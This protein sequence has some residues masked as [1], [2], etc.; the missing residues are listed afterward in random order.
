MTLSKFVKKQEKPLNLQIIRRIVLQLMMQFES[1]HEN[2][3]VH[4]ELNPQSILVTDAAL[5]VQQRLEQA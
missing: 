4:L 5:L 3:I 2:G 1:L